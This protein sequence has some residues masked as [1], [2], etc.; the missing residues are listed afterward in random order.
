MQK[1][2]DDAQIESY[3]MKGYLVLPKVFSAGEVAAW[4][5]ESRRLLKLGLGHED[6]SR[7]VLYQNPTGFSVVVR[8]NPVIDI[9]SIFKSLVQDRRILQ[10][11][12]DLYGHEMLLFKDKLIYKMPGVAGYKMH[13]DYSS[14]QVFPKDLV[15]V[16]V[17]IDGADAANGGVEF[18]PGYH[19]RLLSTE[20]ES[21]YMTEAEADQIDLSKGESVKT[22]PGDVV[23]FDCLT[24]HR[25]GVN[26]ANRLRRQL[27][28]TYSSASNGDLYAAQLAYIQE[29][30]RNKRGD[31]G[32]RLFFR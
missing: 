14:W 18:F 20:G 3:R 28:L 26:T 29:V 25:S 1:A 19:D 27:Y 6:N 5:V 11:V 30:E 16:I 22:E 4:D 7:T 23:I 21:R 8:L 24:P 12:G 10:P 17:S 9:S 32:E 31:A 13:Q 2:L 15:N